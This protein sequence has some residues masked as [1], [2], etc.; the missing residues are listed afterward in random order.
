VEEKNEVPLNPCDHYM[1][2]PRSAVVLMG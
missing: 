2:S 1:M